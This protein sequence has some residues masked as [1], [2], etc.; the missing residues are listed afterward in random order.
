MTRL[1]R[2]GWR[3]VGGSLLLLVL[4]SLILAWPAVT[5]EMP[6]TLPTTPSPPVM[7]SGLKGAGAAGCSVRAARAA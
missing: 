1:T 3:L 7:L 4:A 5:P 2:R 6:L